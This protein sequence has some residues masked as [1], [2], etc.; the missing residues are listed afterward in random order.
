MIAKITTPNN[1]DAKNTLF[2]TSKLGN[3]SFLI[4]FLKM[5]TVM[6]YHIIAAIGATTHKKNIIAIT[7]SPSLIN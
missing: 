3:S 7:L 4:I 6:P 1:I 5:P 2:K